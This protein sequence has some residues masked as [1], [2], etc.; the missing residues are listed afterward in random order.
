MQDRCGDFWYNSEIM[1]RLLALFLVVLGCGAAQAAWYWPFGGKSDL[2]KVPPVSELMEPV[3]RLIDSAADF[4]EDGKLNEAVEE[5]KKALTEIARIKYEN[6]DRVES[7]EFATLR[8][9]EAFVNSAIDSLLLNQARL[10]ARSVAVTDTTELE[11]KYARLKN[12]DAVSDEKTSAIAAQRAEEQ[13]EQDVSDSLRREAPAASASASSA[14][15]P[16]A[17]ATRREKLL[18]ASQDIQKKDY[19]AAKLTIR[20]LLSDKPNDAAALNLR[21]A[22]EAAMGDYKAAERTLD[23]SIQSNP[24]SHYAY[25][26]M[27]RLFL[28]ARGGEGKKAAKRYYEAGR[29]LGGPEDS[30]LEERLK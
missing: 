3:S 2:E 28:E 5:Y 10:N 8:N 25:Y 18:L 11:K 27:A 30:K 29:S 12:K 24:R 14:P 17:V 4:A 16:R 6:P 20:E 1:G 23:Q 26:N 22:M 9:K 15:R 19:E 7:P 13:A 21:A